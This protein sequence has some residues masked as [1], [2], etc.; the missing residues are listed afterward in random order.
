M[1][2]RAAALALA[3]LVL[4]TFAAGAETDSSII[5]LNGL[6]LTYEE[7]GS[8]RVFDFPNMHVDMAVGLSGQI[9]SLQLTFSNDEGQELGAVVQIQGSEVLGSVGSVTSVFSLNLGRIITDPAKAAMV[10]MALSSAVSLGNVSLVGLLSALTME[11]E[12]GARVLQASVPTAAFAAAAD[13]ALQRAEG[14]EAAQ[15]L[16]FEA[17]REKLQGLD[18]TLL[19]EFSYHPGTGVFSMSIA[20]ND[21]R[22]SLSGEA[23]VS[24][25]PFAYADIDLEANRIDVM[26]MTDA[27]IAALNDEMNL[28]AGRLINQA[29][30]TGLTEFIP[31]K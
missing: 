12:D 28:M 29:L 2:K 7:A 14:F 26:D 23:Q 15:Q 17:I 9:P 5:A 31:A 22:L 8:A 30:A 25:G 4:L 1:M 10:T 20:Q 6:K 16:D 3:L 13:N 19:A 21:K 11:G 18:D 27:D 24:T